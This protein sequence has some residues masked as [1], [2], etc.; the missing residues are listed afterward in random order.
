MPK[1][2]CIFS[3]LDGSL[4]RSDHT[5]HPDDIATIQTLRS[6]GVPVIIATGRHHEI[7]R[8]VYD[9]V[10]GSIGYP[11]ITCN[12]SNLYD[13]ETESS[14]RCLLIPTHTVAELWEYIQNNKLIA[15]LYTDECCYYDPNDKRLDFRQGTIT[16]CGDTP[17]VV[18][19]MDEITDPTQYNVTKFVIS[20]ATEDTQQGFRQA[21]PPQSGLEF[22]FS[23]PGILDV[24]CVGGDKGDAV[25][26]ICNHYG[27]DPANVLCLGDN[28]NDY[29][30]LKA[31]GWSVAP[32][33]ASDGI[34][35]VCRFITSHHDNR[36]LTTAIRELFP[37][38]ID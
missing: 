11:T 21:F 28:Y 19:S 5:I 38:Y 31:A 37:Q 22:C 10:G 26:W 35:E 20:A 32:Q 3:D 24:N 2:E 6:K 4:L 36:P 15:Y 16:I 18:H 30:M 1:L 12:G 34:K 13:Y 23:G 33:N 14:V 29:G 8:P 7:A 25:K 9:I 27:L 17:V